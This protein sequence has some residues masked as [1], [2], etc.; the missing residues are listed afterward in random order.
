[1]TARACQRAAICRRPPDLCD[2]ACPEFTAAPA[3]ADDPSRRAAWWA[4]KN[5][6]LAC[7]DT[8]RRAWLAGYAAAREEH[9]R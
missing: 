9:K 1:M 7:Q 3:Q 4:G 6:P 8:A 5:A 2:A